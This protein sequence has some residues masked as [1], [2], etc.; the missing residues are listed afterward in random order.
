MTDTDRSGV[1]PPLPESETGVAPPF[2]ENEAVAAPAADGEK[3]AVAAAKGTDWWSE[4]KAI[5]TGFEA[6]VGEM[7]RLMDEARG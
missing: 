6:S 4:I 5:F 7:R 1:A 2:P 3:P